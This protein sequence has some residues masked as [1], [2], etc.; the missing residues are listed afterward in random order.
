MQLNLIAKRQEEKLI[1]QYL[2]ENASDTLADK[3]NNGVQIE[4]DGK[5][6]QLTRVRFLVQLADKVVSLLI[7]QRRAAGE[8]GVGLRGGVICHENVPF[9]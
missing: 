9:R 7:G 1:K 4:K 8:G 2:E 6:Q 5:Q 3:I